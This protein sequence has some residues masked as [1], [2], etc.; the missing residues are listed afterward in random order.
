MSVKLTDFLDAKTQKRIASYPDEL[1]TIMYSY[2]N[3]PS[4][5]TLR[6]D[7]K[8]ENDLERFE[9]ELRLYELN[10]RFV[11]KQLDRL[12]DEV[13]GQLEVV[14]QAKKALCQHKKLGRP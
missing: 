13:N 3:T 2:L 1:K 8:T 11:K 7:L 14:D 4:A 10:L 12:L 9:Q 6:L 5:D